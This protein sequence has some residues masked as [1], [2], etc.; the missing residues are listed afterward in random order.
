MKTSE[1]LKRG[2]KE[3][4]GIGALSLGTAGSEALV[5]GSPVRVSPDCTVKDAGAPR[6]AQVLQTSLQLLMIC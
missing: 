5:E 1:I 6:T 2:E 4:E 3:F